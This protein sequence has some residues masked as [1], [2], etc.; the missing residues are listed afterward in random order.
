MPECDF[1]YPGFGFVGWDLFGS[2][3]TFSDLSTT[4]GDIIVIT[5]LWKERKYTVV[6]NSNGGSGTM[7]NQS[8]F[9]DIPTPLNKNTFTR[10][11]F[12]VS[13]WNT[14][15]D[16]TGTNYLSEASVTNLAS[17]KGLITLYAVWSNTGVLANGNMLIEG[18][19]YKKTAMKQVLFES[20]TIT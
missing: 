12:A 18:I 9:C 11:G 6:F 10:D 1:I 16:G 20:T 3:K 8:I 7:E 15:S 17:E 2:A 19:E 14:S 13:S 4:D 5:A